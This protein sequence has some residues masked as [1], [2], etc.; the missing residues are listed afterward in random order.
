MTLQTEISEE[1]NDHLSSKI[2]TESNQTTPE[3]NDNG[4]E[5]IE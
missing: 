5:P 3:E 1:E 2:M 4:D